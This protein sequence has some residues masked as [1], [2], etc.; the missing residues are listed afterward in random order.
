MDRMRTL[1]D[2]S[3]FFVSGLYP[4]PDRMQADSLMH[5]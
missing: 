1:R 3:Y 5:E 4:S 2:A